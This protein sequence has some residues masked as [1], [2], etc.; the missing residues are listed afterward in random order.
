MY[1]PWLKGLEN[2]ILFYE[3]ADSHHEHY[4]PRLASRS[5]RRETTPRSQL[6]AEEVQDIDANDAGGSEGP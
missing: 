2:T 5:L 4:F 6:G 1:I 3:L